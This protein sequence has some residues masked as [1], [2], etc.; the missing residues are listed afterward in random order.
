MTDDP[1]EPDEILPPESEPTRTDSSD[2]RAWEQWK[3]TLGPIL[4]GLAIDLLDVMTSGPYGLRLGFGL[5]AIATF[6]I[7]SLYEIPFRYKLPL[8]VAAGVYCMIPATGR[9]P[10][11]TILGF[12]ARVRRR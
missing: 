5:G 10:L 6:C 12:L 7:C 8:A 11:G 1:I 3:R 4:L 2:R 9:L